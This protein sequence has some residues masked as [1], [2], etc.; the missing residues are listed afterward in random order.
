MELRISV[1]AR[2]QHALPIWQDFGGAMFLRPDG[3]ILGSDWDRPGFVEI[4][5]DNRPNRDMVHAARG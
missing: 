1:I 4:L 2:A 3:H 5:T